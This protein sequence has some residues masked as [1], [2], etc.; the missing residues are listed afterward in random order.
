MAFLWTK[1]ILGIMNPLSLDC[2]SRIAEESGGLPSVL[3]ATCPRSINPGT[4]SN[5]IRNDFMIDR[6]QLSELKK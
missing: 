1:V 4:N 5:T 3:M 2:R 6:L